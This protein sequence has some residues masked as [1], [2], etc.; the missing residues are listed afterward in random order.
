MTLGSSPPRTLVHALD[1]FFSVPCLCRSNLIAPC[2]PCT[3]D[4]Q[5]DGRQL[6]PENLERKHPPVVYYITCLA[7]LKN[8][9]KTSQ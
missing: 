7:P 5:L 9:L 2:H 6:E 1:Q 8:P 3:R 4:G